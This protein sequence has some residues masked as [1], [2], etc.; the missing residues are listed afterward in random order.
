M[1][2]EWEQRRQMLFQEMGHLHL[3]EMEQAMQLAKDMELDV[4]V[5]FLLCIISMEPQFDQLLPS[6]Q[7]AMDTLRQTD[8]EVSLSAELVISDIRAILKH[9][10]HLPP[11]HLKNILGK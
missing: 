9:P 2:N 4:L 1:V 6:V 8:P 10:S 5:N 11:L 7:L 3:P